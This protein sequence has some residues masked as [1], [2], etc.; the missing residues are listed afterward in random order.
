MELPSE[1]DL[2]IE[3]YDRDR[4]A[5]RHQGKRKLKELTDIEAAR[6]RLEHDGLW[7]IVVDAARRL[8]EAESALQRG[9]GRERD[10]DL[11]E[12]LHDAR[13]AL[14]SVEETRSEELIEDVAGALEKDLCEVEECYHE[15]IAIPVETCGYHALKEFVDRF[16]IGDKTRVRKAIENQVNENGEV[17]NANGEVLG[18]LENGPLEI[19]ATIAERDGDGKPTVVS[20]SG[21]GHEVTIEFDHRIPRAQ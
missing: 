15:T 19:D 7:T 14:E 3:T 12:A 6:N 17:V 8:D 9:H 16:E 5:L 20:L 21:N 13:R 1:E 11:L 2:T 10:E 4:A 18:S